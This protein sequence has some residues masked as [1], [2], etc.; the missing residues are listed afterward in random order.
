MI[1]TSQTKMRDFALRQLRDS[2]KSKNTQLLELAHISSKNCVSWRDIQHVFTFY[3]WMKAM[4][5]DL[6][7]HGEGGTTTAGK[8]QR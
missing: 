4:Y 8:G 2:M 7:P 5:D 1:V 6:K 3:Q